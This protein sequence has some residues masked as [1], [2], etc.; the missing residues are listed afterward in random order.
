MWGGF[1]DRLAS[2]GTQPGE[3]SVEA[4]SSAIAGAGG[5][6]QQQRLFRLVKWV[7]ETLQEAGKPL[8]NSTPLL[9]R[10]YATSI[11]PNR[12]GLAP[13]VLNDLGEHVQEALPGVK[14]IRLAAAYA[15]LTGTG[16]RQQELLTLTVPDLSTTSDGALSLEVG[17]GAKRRRLV[18]PDAAVEPVQA[19]LAVRPRNSTSALLFVNSQG[20]KGLNNVTLWRQLQRI[21]AGAVNAEEGKRLGSGLIRASW[22]KAQQEAG[23]TPRA[24]Q[25][26]LGHRDPTST[27][28]LLA[29]T[30]LRRKR[31][32]SNGDEK[33]AQSS[34]Q[35]P[36]IKY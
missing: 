24:V 26:A 13:E 7:Y 2:A 4:L 14:G 23:N 9:E 34:D 29:R 12:V 3:E 32:L 1:R 31:R 30:S 20:T 27:T 25:T 21:G 33:G 16:I 11:R 17:K 10:L 19:W 8:S 22:A 6:S 5:Y 36:E 28:E 18:L 35:A 15:I